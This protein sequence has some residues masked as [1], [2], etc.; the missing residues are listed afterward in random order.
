MSRTLNL[1]ALLR[2]LTSLQR[3]RERRWFF[4]VCAGLAARF[5]LDLLLVRVLTLGVFV[6]LPLTVGPVYLLLG[7]LLRNRALDHP[8]PQGER[9]FWTRHRDAGNGGD[10][11]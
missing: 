8:D 5:G 6:L 7:L 10:W 1:D 11:T 3:D 9:T 4:G 2:G